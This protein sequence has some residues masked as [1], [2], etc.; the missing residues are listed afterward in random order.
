MEQTENSNK[1][2][3]KSTTAKI[4]PN[5]NNNN[6]NHYIAFGFHHNTNNTNNQNQ[7]QTY[8]PLLPLPP[9]LPPLQLPFP[10]NHNFRSRTHVHKP[11][12]NQNH[13]FLA[14]PSDSKIQEISASKV[15][16][17]QNDVSK[18]KYGR[19]V[20]AAATTTESL[21]VARRPDSGGVEGQV[22][23]LLANHFLV[24]FDPSQRIFHYDVEIS[25]HPSKDIARL[26]KKKL[27][28]DHSVMLSGALPVYDGGR[29]IYSPIEF[30]NNKIEFYISLPIPSSGS[31]KSGEMVKLQKEEQQIKLF[32]V[33]IKLISK[34]DGKE[35]NSYLNKEGDD[36]GS[37]LPQEYLHALDVV[38][39][40]S[41][42]EKCITAG[43]SFYSSCMGGEKDIGGGAVALRGFFQSLRPTQQGLALNVD[44]SV[45][46]FHESI[47]VITYLEKRL[48]FLHD[49]SHRKTRGLT[50]DEKKEVE[51]ALKNIR[52]FVCHRETV[53]RYRIYSL[54]EEVTENLCF[55]DRDGKILRIVNYFKDHY[56]YDIL[57]R[58]L[59]CLQIS[60]SKPC[61]LPMELCMICEGQKFLGKLS[62]DQ[63][64]R[65][66][67]MGCQRPRERKAIIDRV[68]TGSVG[69]TSG[70]HASD[71][72]L[73]ISKEMTQL[74]GRILQPPKLKL[75][76]RGQVRNLIPSRLDRQWNLLDSHVFEGTRVERW[77]LMSFG[78]TSDQKS[79]IPK[80]IN[81][82]CQRCEQLG[83]F[84]N[85]NTVLN[86]QFEPLHLLN[87]VKNLETKLN[88][89]HRASFNNLQLVICVMERKHKGYADLKRI[90]ETSIGVVTQCCLYP[91]LG[92][93]SSQF[94]AN[95][96]LK[97][98]AKVGG[99]T[100]ALYNSL[101]SQIPR[102]FKHDCPVIFMG[103]DVTHPHPL[104]DFSPSVAAVVGS[105][106]WPAAN[107]YV[108]RMRSQT[109][110]Q[111]IIQD[112][113]TMVGEIIDDF[114]EELLKLPERIIFF[115]DGVSETQFLKVLKEELQAI[116]MACS[117]F[118]GYKPPITFVVVQ[119][120]HHT[121]LFPCELD[122]STTKNTL[123]N[124]NILPGT[125]VDTVIT[126]PS[127]FD[128]YL[129]SHWGVKGTSR[130]IHYHVLWDENQFTSDELQKLVYNLCYTFVR[131]TKPISLVPPAYYAHLAAYRGRLYLE[132]SDLST[133]TRSS[134]ISRAA[135]PKTTPLPKLTENIKKL[136][137][138]C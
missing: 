81:Q 135:P 19:R 10:Q 17:R 97:I 35:L 46:A 92:K 52:V 15:L 33:N 84:L 60:R 98:N 7:Y 53:Q 95:L 114:Y 44:F 104:D 74:Y 8:P 118:P 38:L 130:P 122:L 119:K 48:D 85:K 11:S 128:F 1:C 121:R 138:Y 71:F 56:N 42:T 4:C 117:R 26:I 61:Y 82:L 83:I 70:N 109:H 134:N 30:Q 24:Q 120:R 65:I 90:A 58:N 18:Q 72:K 125:V 51:K 75:G 132:R 69:P 68:V 87:N 77:A 110:R 115:R 73:Q 14:T 21:V 80:F 66:L 99:C 25:P 113:S 43:R 79:H 64:A 5:N 32:R 39:R 91:N 16:Q 107:K 36:S 137:F 127:E 29:T 12:F 23:S 54:T 100:V 2:N 124:E 59:P 131:C 116:R 103:A 105:V 31:N 27:V 136:M 112:L 67:K 40:E 111:E 34:F 126:H 78:G 47:G 102:L 13:P 20:K 28:E 93:I 106:N 50:N 101:P 22:I 55:Q 133:L 76:D 41:P 6:N 96:A 62:D 63:T 57:Y 94:L 89:L 37:P 49:I 108:S 88:K 3:S 45:T 86:P 123:F 129:C 9:L